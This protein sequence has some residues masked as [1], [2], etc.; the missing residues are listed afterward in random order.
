M[1]QTDFNM[2]LRMNAKLLVRELTSRNIE[3][4][5]IDSVTQTFEARLGEHRELFVDIDSSACAMSAGFIAD[6]KYVA[7]QLLVRAGIKTPSGRR[8]SSELIENLDQLLAEIPA[9]YIIKPEVG[10]GGRYVLFASSGYESVERSIRF[11]YE[12]LTPVPILVETY[13]PGQCIRVFITENQHMA[14]LLVEPPW[15]TGDGQST[16]RELALEESTRRLSPRQ[17]CSGEVI[18][19]EFSELFLTTHGLTPEYVPTVGQKV[20]LRLNSNTSTGGTTTDI[21]DQLHPSISALAL[22]VL[23]TFPGLRFAGIDFVCLDYTQSTLC[24]D[25]VALEVNSLPGLGMHMAPSRGK[26]RN[27]AGLLV[28]LIFPE[29]IISQ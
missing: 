1:T 9:P 15:V 14:A 22:K 28:D 6:H 24:Q 26:S 8:I 29:T 27:V 11:L 7:K 5:L 17:N 23:N 4:Q 3:I 12:R 13:Y 19:D 16:I 2:Q 21:T 10:T 20:R 25:V 18:L